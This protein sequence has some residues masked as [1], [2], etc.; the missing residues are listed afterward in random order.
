MPSPAL[1][2]TADSG[3]TARG[4]LSVS[5]DAPPTTAAA[6][7]T[8]VSPAGAGSSAQGSTPHLLVPMVP[9]AGQVGQQ[10]SMSPSARVS[11]ALREAEIS[12]ALTRQA[13]HRPSEAVAARPVSD[14]FAK[15][16]LVCFRHAEEGWLLGR[17]HRAH[18]QGRG[19]EKLYSVAPINAKDMLMPLQRTASGM[20]SEADEADDPRGTSTAAVEV[21]T[22]DLQR[23]RRDELLPV[24]EEAL[25]PVSDLLQLPRLHEAIVLQQLHRMFHRGEPYV[26]LGDRVL[27]SINPGRWNQQLHSDELLQEYLENQDALPGAHIWDLVHHVFW[28]VLT[29]SQADAAPQALVFQGCAGSG[30]SECKKLA[31]RLLAA[32][33]ARQANPGVARERTQM[34]G[35]LLIETLSVVE[36][37]SNAGTHR[38]TNSSRSARWT[39]L[40]ISPGGA[41]LGAR[42]KVLLLDRSRVVQPPEGERSFHCFYQL[43]SG[44]DPASRKRLGLGDARSY[45]WLFR[46][47]VS[48]D[49]DD[50]RDAAGYRHWRRVLGDCGFAPFELDGI[51]QVLAGIIHLRGVSVSQENP[52]SPA[53][54]STESEEKMRIAAALWGLE[55]HVLFSEVASVTTLVRGARQTRRLNAGL[56]HE[57]RDSVCK[58]MYC[59]LLRWLLRR[60]NEHLT[61]HAGRSVVRAGSSSV[62]RV[63]SIGLLDLCGF[64]DNKLHGNSLEQLLV[65]GANEEVQR[66]YNT[67]MF[68]EDVEVCRQEGID[69]G[70]LLPPD[71]E[72]TIELITGRGG[73]LSALDD[74]SHQGMVGGDKRFLE[75]VVFYNRQH[76]SLRISP[77]GGDN[78]FGIVHS[79]GLVWYGPVSGWCARNMNSI[80]PGVSKLLS[81]SNSHFVQGLATPEGCDDAN[82][83]EGMDDVDAECDTM[84]RQFRH[85]LAE[86]QDLLSGRALSWVRCLNPGSV[87]GIF[88]GSEVLSQ[89]RHAGIMETILLQRHGYPV[90][91]PHDYFIERY[92]GTLRGSGYDSKDGTEGTPTIQGILS[93]ANLDSRDAQIGTTMVF[94]KDGAREKLEQL[95][96]EGEEQQKLVHG[97]LSRLQC[98]RGVPQAK[99]APLRQP[100]TG[101]VAAATQNALRAAVRRWDQMSAHLP[102]FLAFARAFLAAR[103]LHEII[104]PPA[105]SAGEPE[106]DA[107]GGEEATESAPSEVGI[108]LKSEALQR[109]AEL[110][111]AASRHASHKSQRDPG[112]P[113]PE[114]VLEEEPA[115]QHPDSLLGKMPDPS[116]TYRLHSAALDH[117]MTGLRSPRFK[118]HSFNSL[119][120]KEARTLTRQNADDLYDCIS[121]GRREVYAPLKLSRAAVGAIRRLVQ[122]GE[123][124]RRHMER[125]EMA[126]GE[127]GKKSWMRKPAEGE[128][129]CALGP[130]STKPLPNGTITAVNDGRYY[131][132]LDGPLALLKEE[133]V[134][135][136]GRISPKSP[137]T[138][139]PEER[140]KACIPRNAKYFVFAYPLPGMQG[141]SGLP[142][143]WNSPSVLFVVFGGFIYLDE[144]ERPAAANCL[145]LGEGLFFNGPY[146]WTNPDAVLVMWEQGRLQP[147]TIQPLL[148]TGAK[149]FSWLLPGEDFG[150]CPPPAHGGFVYLFREP[151]DP[152]H[153]DDRYFIVGEPDKGK[154][155]QLADQDKGL[156]EQDDTPQA[157]ALVQLPQIEGES[158]LENIKV[159]QRVHEVVKTVIAGDHRVSKARQGLEPANP[160]TLVHMEKAK[161]LTPFRDDGGCT[162][163]AGSGGKVRTENVLSPVRHHRRPARDFVDA[164]GGHT[165]WS[166]AGVPAAAT[167]LDLSGRTYP[168]ETGVSTLL[169]PSR[170]RPFFMHSMQSNALT[171]CGRSVDGHWKESGG[172]EWCGD[173]P[174]ETARSPCQSPWREAYER[175]L[176][177]GAPSPTVRPSD[178]VRP[179]GVDVAFA[180]ELPRGTLHAAYGVAGGAPGGRRGVPQ[181]ARRR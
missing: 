44:M 139:P 154:K 162:A 83:L 171:A 173:A 103:Q 18:G 53:T 30:K 121:Q 56:V 67:D 60:L 117:N 75:F 39:D 17:V 106:P 32:A 8:P 137:V 148:D 174:D 45:E 62:Q 176:C 119:I 127:G 81:D 64:E 88:Q 24:S 108:P 80:N 65:N 34:V 175:G 111:R 2:A 73:V 5:F 126:A 98:A 20:E 6:A 12:R 135:E 68:A 116:E 35:Q 166:S 161:S 25:S 93:V 55:P 69:M 70:G 37:F 27:V 47:V 19:S 129:P 159:S 66:L 7:A 109:L 82:E 97:F 138:L 112:P 16:A 89:L 113:P 124:H 104:S 147:I 155:K 86:L 91:L 177:G 50:A 107:E 78:T 87:R 36:A 168:F 146:E 94:L 115:P 142:L 11:K 57:A 10:G 3:A 90:R 151:R 61:Q 52:R 85:D 136:S 28:S 99:D 144:F 49:A 21:S 79:S 102:V 1:K 114:E 4:Q 38:Q 180:G 100:A 29:A 54:W 128:F 178:V 179:P 74:Q 181:D 132:R 169:S 140:K 145:M 31:L 131:V 76:P 143:E 22:R 110:K 84:A 153:P 165:G 77:G 150:V 42:L 72:P 96:M 46:H 123:L 48:T 152:P 130:F 43:L 163:P 167:K 149:Y 14:P 40:I 26:R 158:D 33:A 71:T 63:A 23:L 59:S 156:N 157:E 95:R 51:D 105:S 92:R 41:L 141:L 125:R 15:G 9:Q 120:L 122:Q 133:C 172:T 13:A 170:S 134:P 118:Q 164:P 101:H 160:T 58:M